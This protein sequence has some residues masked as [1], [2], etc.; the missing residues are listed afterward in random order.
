MDE[1]IYTEIERL[2][3]LHLTELRARY[4]EVFVKVILQGIIVLIGRQERNLENAL[5]KF[6]PVNGGP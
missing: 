3:C 1:R 2:G 6:Q 5:L 4:R